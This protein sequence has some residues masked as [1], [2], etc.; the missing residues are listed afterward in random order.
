[1]SLKAALPKA[2]KELRFHFCQTS[3]T[4]NGLREFIATNYTT[5]KKA[6]PHLPIL[7]R[8]A[9]GSQARAFARFE[10]GREK[11]VVLE[12]LSAKDIEQK[13]QDLVK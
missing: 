10:F 8:E 2:L 9:S 5:I 6:N 1:M 12:N 7:I 13:L 3:P 4:S 11:K